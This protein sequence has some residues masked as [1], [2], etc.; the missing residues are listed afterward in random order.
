M[1]SKIP[2]AAALALLLAHQ[3]LASPAPKLETAEGP[4]TGKGFSLE[5]PRCASWELRALSGCSELVSVLPRHAVVFSR[6]L[7]G[8]SSKG[9]RS[10]YL[11]GSFSTLATGDR[12]QAASAPPVARFRP[13]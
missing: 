9:H 3:A 12:R 13:R 5:V 7:S 10:A 8:D 1:I 4:D 2:T 6:N 11:E